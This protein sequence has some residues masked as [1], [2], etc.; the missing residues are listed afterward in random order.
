MALGA[1]IRANIDS[2]GNVVP[3]R[4]DNESPKTSN[5]YIQGAK[6][7]SDV[8]SHSLGMISIS[9]DGEKYI[10]STIIKKIVKFQQI[11]QNHS[12]LRHG[13]EIMNLRYMFFKVSLKDL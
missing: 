12:N 10:N 9:P 3:A 4:W 8:T 2:N 11:I 13:P 1:A 5:L 7:V 6:A